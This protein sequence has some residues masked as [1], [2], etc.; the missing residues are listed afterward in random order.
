MHRSTIT[1]AL[2][3]CVSAVLL[4]AVA[5]A[6]PAASG[7]TRSGSALPSGFRV[8]SL[9][10]VSPMQG[11]LLGVGPC[12]G[13]TC[14]TVL[15]TTDGGATWDTLATLAAPLT[16]DQRSGV[17]GIRF[18][19][20]LHGWA[21]GPA[22]WATNDGGLTWKKKSAPGGGKLVPV[23]GADADAVY[24]LVS[25]CRLNEPPSR[26][27]APTLW[28]A[29]PGGGSW[30]QAALTLPKGLITN[31]AVIA[32]HGEVAY[33]VV[34]TETDPDVFDVTT[35]GTQWSSRPDPCVKANDEQLVD[36]A[37]SSDTKVAI[38]C[39]SD[40]GVGQA[41]KR[42]F[43]SNDTGETTSAAGS[44]PREG[45]NT[46]IA[47]SPNGTLAVSSWSA[48][49]SWIYRNGGG[50]TWTTSVSLNDNGVGWNDLV[51]TSN[52]LGW[53]V[54]GPAAVYPGNR[55]GELWRTKDGGVTW[56]PA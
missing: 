6:G 4:L 43:R 24:A 51:F 56:S 29:T 5:I 8:Q 11:W 50:T 2:S 45:I 28:R 20:A 46:L 48:P 1:T 7:A 37:P 10:W 38:V 25:A 27:K 44:T 12:G 23:L 49:G 54:Y 42:V 14:T 40:P 3:L 30:T 26:C 16:S 41:T 31:I 52:R 18:A 34:P 32:M 35:D 21:F 55:P 22:L 9:S 53:V 15:G 17:T 36:V 19:D 39:L 47:A 13:S 33:L